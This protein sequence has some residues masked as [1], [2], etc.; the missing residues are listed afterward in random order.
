MTENGSSRILRRRFGRKIRRRQRR[1]ADEFPISD[2]HDCEAALDAATA[3]FQKLRA[4]PPESVARFLD[5][6]AELIEARAADLVTIAN[7]ET[8]LPAAPRM[9]DVELPR[10]T[11]QLRQ[12]AAA[13]REG[14]WRC[15]RSIQS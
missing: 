7:T 1:S 15:R 14:S 8:A 6:Y 5:V 9:K 13:A 12:A 2:W 10:T 3:A 11:S 4:M